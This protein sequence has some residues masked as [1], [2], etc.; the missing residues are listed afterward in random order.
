M[1]SL[2]RDIDR[3]GVAKEIDHHNKDQLNK[4]KEGKGHWKRELASNSE[5]AV[6]FITRHVNRKESADCGSRYR[7]RQIEETS[8][9]RRTRLNDY[10]RRQKNTM[11]KDVRL[12]SKSRMYGA[13]QELGSDDVKALARL[14]IL[15]GEDGF[16]ARQ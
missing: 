13:V 3:E 6:Q 12:T 2:T 1:T 16:L 5:S 9:L 15:N 11:Q 7:S 8:T 4:Q 14:C 10:R